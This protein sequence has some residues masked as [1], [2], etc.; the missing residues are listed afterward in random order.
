M[1]RN[2]QDGVLPGFHAP[3]LGHPKHVSAKLSSPAGGNAVIHPR[4][5]GSCSSGAKTGHLAGIWPPTRAPHVHEAKWQGILVTGL[6]LKLTKVYRVC[7]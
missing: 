2:N 6:M 5:G 3:P 7:S 4:F 1:W